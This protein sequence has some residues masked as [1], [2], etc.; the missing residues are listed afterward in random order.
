M[1]RLKERVALI[2][3]AVPGIDRA[4]GAGFAHEWAFGHIKDINDEAVRKAAGIHARNAESYRLGV[5]TEDDR[6]KL[7]SLVLEQS[8]RL[9]TFDFNA[10]VT[11]SQPLPGPQDP[12]SMS[13]SRTGV[14]FKRH[15]LMV[16]SSAASV[17][18]WR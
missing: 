9:D 15:V 7:S 17:A 18:L 6:K 16:L 1:P 8:G 10:R 14:R 3:G 11:G 13:R 4:T 12:R 2:T 5:R